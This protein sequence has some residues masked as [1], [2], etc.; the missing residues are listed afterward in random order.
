[1]ADIFREIDEELRQDRATRL[2][3]QY[4]WLVVAGAVL[5]VAAVG[6]YRYWQYYDRTSRAGDSAA[7][8]AARASA[9]AGSVET[10]IS[11]L[12]TLAT[13]ANDGYAILA[14]MQQA[15]L[16]ARNGDTEG[17]LIA[18]QSVASDEDA[19]LVLRDLA[20]L[21][22]V[23]VQLTT[24]PAD[25]LFREIDRL[26]A[27]GNTW[28]PMALELKGLLLLD[29]GDTAAAR[30]IFEE[31]SDDSRTPRRMRSRVTELLHALPSP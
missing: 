8:D 14:R 7:Y 10:A 25:D 4:G 6:G 3:K 17:A 23:S 9:S 19:P 29:S 1:M 26:A 2:W 18:W 31:L 13:E 30:A 21:G 12:G 24:A 5:I 15:A 22:S 16:A 27:V 20:R 28:R 11:E